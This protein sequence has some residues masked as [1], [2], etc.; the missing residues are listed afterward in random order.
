MNEIEEKLMPK[1][2]ENLQITDGNYDKSLAVKCVNGTFVG[3]RVD[4]IISYKGIPFV[5]R[6]PIGDLRWK[7]PMISY[8]LRRSNAEA[9]NR[10]TVQ[11][12][13]GT[14]PSER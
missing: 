2:G 3:K 11:S 12:S 6:Q 7:A 1:Y 4:D 13:I 9:S 8:L 5:G 10:N 14:A